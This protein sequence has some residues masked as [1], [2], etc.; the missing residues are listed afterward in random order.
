MQ[1]E[2]KRAPEQNGHLLCFPVLVSR[3]AWKP[4][5]IVTPGKNEQLLCFLKTHCNFNALYIQP[6]PKSP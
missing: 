2:S 5:F 4:V 3:I 1:L 6:T